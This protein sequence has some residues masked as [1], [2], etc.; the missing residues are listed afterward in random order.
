ML[1]AMSGMDWTAWLYWIG[2][3]VLALAGVLKL[4]VEIR[5]P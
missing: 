5:E 4:P 3:G 1:M 2:S